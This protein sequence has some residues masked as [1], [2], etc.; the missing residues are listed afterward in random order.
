MI[1]LMSFWK[2]L[3]CVHNELANITAQF[4]RCSATSLAFV[5]MSMPG[6]NMCQRDMMLPASS[7]SIDQHMRMHPPDK[8]QVNNHANAWSSW[9]DAMRLQ[10]LSV[11][12]STCIASSLNFTW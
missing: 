11:S 6:H 3:L 2:S 10:L 1:L 5:S 8:M 4:C 12:K 7:T 9:P